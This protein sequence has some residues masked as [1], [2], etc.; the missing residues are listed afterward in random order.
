[1]A[2][3]V[4]SSI[5]LAGVSLV[6]IPG[7][8]RDGRL[9][10]LLVGGAIVFDNLISGIAEHILWQIGHPGVAGHDVTEGEVGDKVVVDGQ[11]ADLVD[12]VEPVAFL[13]TVQLLVNEHPEGMAYDAVLNVL[14]SQTTNPEI[15]AVDAFHRHRAIA[16]VYQR[17]IRVGF[18]EGVILLC[19]NGQNQ[20]RIG[21]LELGDHLVG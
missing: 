9:L 1:M 8:V 16:I 19:V 21:C 3:V 10:G 4:L 6:G 13:K 20:S 15:D 7:I 12:V 17:D 5:I 2:V 11:I 14:L 18:D